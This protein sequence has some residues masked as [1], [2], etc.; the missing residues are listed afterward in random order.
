[1]RTTAPID[2]AVRGALALAAL[3]AL[4]ACSSLGR[5]PEPA[6]ASQPVEPAP[7]RPPAAKAPPRP[8]AHTRAEP[9]S[10][11]REV[12]VLFE[13]DTPEYAEVAKQLAASLTP[14]RYHV[15][16]TDLAGSGGAGDLAAAAKN[17]RRIVITIGRKA[18]DVARNKLSDAPMVFC[19]V[20]NYEDLL[21]GGTVWGVEPLP[22]LG[23]QLRAWRTVDPLLKR[24]G[25]IVSAEHADVVAAAKEQAL[26]AGV[27]IDAEMSAS[28]RETLYLFK[29]L[30]PDVDG[31]WLFPDNRILSRDVLRELLSYAETHDVGVLV[32]NK[33]LLAWGALLSATSRPADVAGRVRDI[34][35]R[36][37]AGSTRGLPAMTPLSA[38]ELQLNPTVAAR[39]GADNASPKPWVLHEPD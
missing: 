17:E 29:R 30:A 3:V 25:L 23:L 15:A 14:A 27:E 39:F 28:D 31:F 13:S 2:R 38:V 4:G 19:Q 35:E 18:A 33:S 24:V 1:M 21:G 10:A 32:S 7:A 36:I 22:P 9:R 34:V 12:L 11:T 5:A 6:T 26:R 20:F 37:A 8:A 16:M